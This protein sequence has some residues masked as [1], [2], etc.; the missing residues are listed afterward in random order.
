MRIVVR[1]G[2]GALLLAVGVR[3]DAA[4]RQPAV[5][6][7][8]SGVELVRID[9]TVVDR[10][11]RPVTDLTRAEFEITE[12][13]HP[14][15]ILS[16]EPVLV[17]PGTTTT[18]GEPASVSAPATLEPEAGR[19]FLVFFD[20]VHIHASTAEWVR[21]RL[22]PFLEGEVKDGDWVSVVAPEGRVHW[23]ARTPW[24]H[25]QLAEVVRRLT[26]RLVRD[27]FSGDSEHSHADWEAMQA[28]EYGSRTGA[29]VASQQGLNG[30]G[31]PKNPLIDESTYAVAQRRVRQTIT[32]LREAIDSLAG[33]RGRKS[34]FLVS[35]GF[36]RAPRLRS[37]Y[38]EVITAARRAGVTV[39]FV[40]AQGLPVEG[41]P[42]ER[43]METM[44]AGSAEIAEQTGGRSFATNDL[45]SPL[46]R[47]LEESSCYY[48]LGI[49]PLDSREGEH[50]VSVRVR[51]RGVS[52]AARNRYF[53]TTLVAAT[54]TTKDAERRA[55][56]SV[57]DA[58]GLSLRV[59]SRIEG[60]MPEGRVAV[61]LSITVDGVSAERRLDLLL[62]GHRLDGPETVDLAEEVTIPDSDRPTPLVTRL[63]VPPG[64][65][66]VRVV[67]AD[68][69]TGAVGSVLHSFAVPSVA[70]AG[71]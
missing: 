26:G 42:G 68:P 40:L 55:L 23:N 30:A 9:V 57:F 17:R 20:D 21:S 66:Q 8:P 19:C 10:D 5:P 69:T 35:E 4:G 22:L 31:P 43:W 59:S 1:L 52:V 47:I 65:W 61:A 6:T 14:H 71:P 12:K 38:D 39:H 48:L 44:A 28:I 15:E 2:L 24:E 34:L 45:A 54:G 51:R 33:F 67:L 53:V 3:A 32:A 50:R 27:P 36:I 11:G 63:T 41:K 60:P 46:R 13:G 62:A 25:R 58:T 56:S 18:P 37:L 49:R 29:D 64:K 7:F 16:F 70:P